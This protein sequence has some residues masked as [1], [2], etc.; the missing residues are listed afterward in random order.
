[1]GKESSINLHGADHERLHKI[2]VEGN[3]VIRFGKESGVWSHHF[4]LDDLFV[5]EGG[6]LKITE[7]REGIDYL[8]VRKNSR[9]LYDV[10]GRIKFEGRAEH[11][12]WVKDYDKDYWQVIPAFPEPGTYGALF[13]AVSL[14][15]AWGRQRRG[16]KLLESQC[17]G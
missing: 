6:T 2:V 14:M 15:A 16:Q 3:S 10:L 17:S 12:A 4:L 9:H 13:G 8:L 5:K 11:R 1:M 7:W